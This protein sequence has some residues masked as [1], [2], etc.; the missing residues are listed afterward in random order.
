LVSKII[1]LGIET[2]GVNAEAK[3]ECSESASKSVFAGEVVV[4]V[5]VV[6]AL[7]VLEGHK[8]DVADAGGPLKIV[9][10]RPHIFV[11]HPSSVDQT[12]PQLGISSFHDEYL[13]VEGDSVPTLPGG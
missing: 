8:V 13:R 2:I 9:I 11:L 5:E 12:L 1:A 10:G 4:V 3:R 7:A 6:D